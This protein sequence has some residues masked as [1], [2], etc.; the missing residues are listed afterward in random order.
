MIFIFEVLISQNGVEV[1]IAVN[2]KD[3]VYMYIQW[4]S[5]STIT[6]LHMWH[7][8]CFNLIVRYNYDDE[9]MLIIKGA[10]DALFENGG[11]NN[12]EAWV[13]LMI[14]V[15]PFINVSIICFPFSWTIPMIHIKFFYIICGSCM[16]SLAKQ[17]QWSLWFKTP[18]FN[19]SLR[20]K[21]SYQ[22]HHSYIFN[23]NI[24]PF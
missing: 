9:E 10:L 16:L 3:M 1:F 14:P 21:T 5:Q 17:L 7:E 19:S 22:W 15:I 24:P 18:P 20:F 23:I 12:I 6:C 4:Y 11:F 13:P 8:C 2:S